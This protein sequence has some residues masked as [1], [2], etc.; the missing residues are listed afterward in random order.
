[1]AGT[2]ARILDTRKT[3]PGLRLLQ[4]YAVRCGGGVN[5]RLRLDDAM[6]I[7]ENH[8]VAAG[9]IG[10]AV[11]AA[12]AAAK[13]LPVVAEVRDL[14]ELRDAVVAGAPAV[15]LDN[16]TPDEV[17]RACRLVDQLRKPVEIEVSGGVTLANA[18]A[19]AEAGAHRLS[20]GALTHS[21]PALDLSMLVETAHR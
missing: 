15:L 2:G 20:V 10:P 14:D 11:R 21:A 3:L 4:K 12:L 18:R 1:V 9:G 7:K 6:L 13:D 16:M 8:A 17:R 19:Y 5:H